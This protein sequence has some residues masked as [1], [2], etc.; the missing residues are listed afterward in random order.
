MTSLI[1]PPHTLVLFLELCDPTS[2]TL[3]N[4]YVASIP[5]PL[6]PFVEVSGNS[7]KHGSIEDSLPDF[8]KELESVPKKEGKNV[9]TR[10]DV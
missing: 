8:H 6:S 7:W 3:Y 1:L 4:V 9:S 2:E 5:G 10:K